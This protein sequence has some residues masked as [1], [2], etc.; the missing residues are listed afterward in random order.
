MAYLNT[1]DKQSSTFLT[2]QF[3]GLNQQFTELQELNAQGYTLLL[4]AK[5]YGR[6]YV[7]KTLSEDTARQTAYSQILRKELEV[8]MLMQ[9]PG[10]VQA[11]GL[12]DVEG[13][14]PSIVMEY[15]DG[16]TLQELLDKG[17]QLPLQQRRLIADE[18]CQALAYV[19]SLGIV[20]RDL[21]PENIMVTR[22]GQRVKLIDFGMADTDQHAILKQPA[23]T[24]NYMAHEQAQASVPDVRNDIYSL[25][26][27]L[28]DLQLGRSYNK[29][30]EHCLKPIG[31]RYQNMTEL[32]QALRR[33]AGR[34]GRLK[35]AATVA[36]LLLLGGVLAWQTWRLQTAAT[37]RTEFLNDIDSLRQQIDQQRAASDSQQQQADQERLSMKQQMVASMGA[38]SDSIR[39][40][41]ADNEQLKSNLNQAEQARRTALQA[42]QRE[43]ERSQ[44]GRHLDT[45]SHWSY[46]W[47]DLTARI[48][49]VNRFIYQYTE[50]HGGGLSPQERDQIRQTMLDQWQTWS[51]NISTRA[52]AVRMKQSTPTPDSFVVH[53][54]RI[55]KDRL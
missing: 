8:L 45:L 24:L 47:P 39:R 5:R 13:L 3:E 1:D 7:L 35:L 42:L 50:H 26:L 55:P 37:D 38:M 25:G 9:H 16:E 31:Q 23:G 4:K 12:E 15:I 19:H 49:N 51:H 53:K 11:F 6:W 32:M 40:L 21:K 20:H 52:N 22:N 27:I 34:G 18:L 28:Q 46:R 41:T 29:V 2:D 10:V 44:V 36:V 33:Q 54:N 14:G 43:M 30:V 48:A 17:L